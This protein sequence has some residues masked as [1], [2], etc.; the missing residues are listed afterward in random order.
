MIGAPSREEAAM[1]FWPGGRSGA[2][3]LSFDDGMES[4][5]TAA[6]A[7]LTGRGLRGT[8]YLNPR[9]SE[10]D[11]RYQ[12]QWRAGLERWSGLHEAGHEIGN[13]SIRHPCS[14]NINVDWAPNSLG[15]TLE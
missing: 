11:P 6:F 5:R 7:A 15:L 1:G 3:A 9:G 2:I 10:D 8:F 13:H 12:P 4:Q 14:L